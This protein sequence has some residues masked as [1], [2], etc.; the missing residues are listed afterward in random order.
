MDL[1]INYGNSRSLL[2]KLQREKER[3]QQALEAQ[4]FPDLA[5]ALYNF[6]ISAFHI[7]DWLITQSRV[8][9][10][11]VHRFLEKVPVLQACRDICNSKKHFKI[12]RYKPGEVQI[13]S[14]ITEIS[15]IIPDEKG[16]Y[17]VYGKADMWV[18]VGNNEVYRLVEFMQKVIDEWNRFH[19]EN[20]I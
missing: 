3:A 4:S 16:N 9:K 5:D 12:T 19:D 18:D 14:T 8:D 17:D 20:E 2:N 1:Q 15:A 11:Q 13:G 7:K 10:D 6:S